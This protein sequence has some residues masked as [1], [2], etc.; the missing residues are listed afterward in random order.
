MVTVTLFYSFYKW[1]DAVDWLSRTGGLDMEDFLRHHS[2]FTPLF[3][4]QGFR[5]LLEFQETTYEQSI[6]QVHLII[7]KYVSPVI[8]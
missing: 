4:K 8:S 2:N 5:D 3:L 7:M 1:H 6:L